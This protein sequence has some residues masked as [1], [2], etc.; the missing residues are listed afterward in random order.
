VFVLHFGRVEALNTQM[1]GLKQGL[2]SRF[3]HS[4]LHRF[5]CHAPR[6]MTAVSV[7]SMAYASNEP[8]M[9]PATVGE[10]W[11]EAWARYIECSSTVG[12]A[13]PRTKHVF[14]EEIS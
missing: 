14:G 7:P 10:W 6:P 5:L 2:I 11:P 1:N 3:V 12:F 9:V 13:N 4:G 8:V